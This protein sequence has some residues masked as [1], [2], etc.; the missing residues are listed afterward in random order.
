L[1]DKALLQQEDSMAVPTVV[2]RTPA[3]AV[4]QLTFVLVVLQKLTV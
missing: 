2:L 1:A 3:V 4:V